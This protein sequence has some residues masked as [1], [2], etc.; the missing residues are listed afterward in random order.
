MF[1]IVSLV[2]FLLVFHI[3]TK[4]PFICALK[5]ARQGNKEISKVNESLRENRDGIY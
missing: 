3:Q 5:L 4:V 1:H 2:F